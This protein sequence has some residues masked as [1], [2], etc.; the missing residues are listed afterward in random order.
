MLKYNYRIESHDVQPNGKI[1]MSALMRILQKIAGD[2]L[3]GSN[4]S[5]MN[6]YN[7]SIAFVLTKITIRT[8]CDIN[9]YD[10]ITVETYPRP[11]KGAAFIR[12]FILRNNGN[13]CAESS[14]TW[15]IIDLTERKILRPTALD[16]IGTLP[17][18]TNNP[19]ELPFVRRLNKFEN[20]KQTDVREVRYSQLDMNGHL[21][22]TFYA[23]YVFDSL[24]NPADLPMNDLFFE[25][26]FKNEALVGETLTLFTACENYESFDFSAIKKSDEKPCFTAF[27][28][29]NASKII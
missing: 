11:V 20:S 29:T 17:T 1:K 23:D 2:D 21:N 24:N 6:L 25:I 12:D 7:H 10:D 16:P 8:H 9:L 5:Y 28:H 14:T 13:L 27:L 26:N 19:V 18:T 3:D 4:L 22:N 15:C